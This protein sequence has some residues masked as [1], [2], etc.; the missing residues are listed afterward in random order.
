MFDA[1]MFHIP[2]AVALH[3]DPQQRILLRLTTDILLAKSEA[4]VDSHRSDVGVY[5]GCMWSEEYLALLSKCVRHP[6][7]Q[8]ELL[9][10]MYGLQSLPQSIFT[11]LVV[12]EKS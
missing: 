9:N 3:M 10:W 1:D 7:S 12:F 2:H 11:V 5:V 4:A 8:F 6:T